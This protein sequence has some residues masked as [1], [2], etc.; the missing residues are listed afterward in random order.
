MLGP[1]FKARRIRPGT[2]SSM[3]TSAKKRRTSKGMAA[4]GKRFLRGPV[5]PLG[6]KPRVSQG[7]AVP[8][9]SINLG[10]MQRGKT[11]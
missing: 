6:Q 10:R 3:L 4:Q 11:A 7:Q 8:A 9:D 5:L 1:Q 2:G